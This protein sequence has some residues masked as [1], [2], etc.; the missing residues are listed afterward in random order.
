MPRGSKGAKAS[1]RETL[2][3]HSSVSW[4][5]FLHEG[6]DAHFN[7][8]I[9]DTTPHFGVESSAL[10]SDYWIQTGFLFPFVAEFK[11]PAS[12]NAVAGYTKQSW[13]YGVASFRTILPTLTKDQQ[14]IWMGFE[15][16]A[17]TGSGIAALALY[18]SGGVPRL[19]VYC[20]G[21]FNGLALDITAAL[22][23]DYT[24]VWHTYTTMM[25]KFGAEYYIDNDLV[26]IAVV[27]PNL[28][29]TDVTYP[30]YGILRVDRPFTPDLTA[31]L[32]AAGQGEELILPIAPPEV[33]INHGQALPPR[34]YRLYQT[35]TNDLLVDT[36]IVAAAPGEHEVATEATSHPFPLFGYA[37]KSINFRASEQGTLSVEVMKQTDNWREYDTMGVTQD[38]VKTY[39]I[40]GESVLARVVYTPNTYPCTISEAEVMLR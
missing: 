26:A 22:P 11:C 40:E 39:S 9:A 4:S 34:C 2:D 5:K 21:A 12:L 14:Q 38:K 36:T 6:I 27:S 30:P 25:T 31:I 15:S 3:I 16:D 7:C 17:G 13:R 18:H 19:R 35:L 20:G 1:L 24:T 8:R 29:F 23:A 32:E 37:G 33:R 10:L 28:A